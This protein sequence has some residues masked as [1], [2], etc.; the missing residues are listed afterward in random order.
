MVLDVVGLV[1]L[2]CFAGGL[3]RLLWLAAT[4]AF[5]WCGWFCVFC[6]IVWRVAF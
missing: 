2:R 5:L 1:G 6:D 4:V 3:L